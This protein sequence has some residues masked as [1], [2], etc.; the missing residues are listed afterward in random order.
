[1]NCLVFVIQP[2]KQCIH[3]DGFRMPPEWRQMCAFHDVMIDVLTSQGIHHYV[4]DFIDRKQRADFVVDK[5]KQAKKS[6]VRDGQ[7]D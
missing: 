2:Q 5:I 1:M 6:L 3:D 4:I 7:D